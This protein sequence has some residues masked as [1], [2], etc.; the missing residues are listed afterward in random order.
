MISSPS[1]DPEV[2]CD[3]EDEDESED[4]CDLEGTSFRLSR[5]LPHLALHLKRYYGGIVMALDESAT[6]TL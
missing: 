3:F 6:P 1:I 5:C 2:A 4:D